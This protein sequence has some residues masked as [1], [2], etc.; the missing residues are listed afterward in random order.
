MPDDLVPDVAGTQEETPE[1]P[2]APARRKRDTTPVLVS[3]CR[4]PIE[5][6]L[7]WVLPEDEAVAYRV[8]Q[9]AFLE[10][11]GLRVPRHVLQDAQQAADFLP[12]LTEIYQVPAAE[13]LQRMLYL[14]GILS[15]NDFSPRNRAVIL[16]AISRALQNNLLKL[17]QE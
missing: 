4:A 7:R 1:E 10:G 15:R 9:S 14:G 11:P 17:L 2:T 13:V 8:P 3:P 6:G 5:D 16:T 12:I